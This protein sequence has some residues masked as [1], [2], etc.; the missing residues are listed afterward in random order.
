MEPIL[1][2]PQEALVLQLLKQQGVFDIQYGKC[3]LNFGAGV[4]QT[5]VKE[6]IVY[7]RLT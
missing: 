5:I 7:K 1:L 6:E 4:L 3:T 2:T